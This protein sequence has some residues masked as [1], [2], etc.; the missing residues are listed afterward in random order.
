MRPDA[1]VVVVGAGVA[2]L[3]AAHELRRAGRDVRVLEAADHVGGRMTTLRRDGFLIDTGAEQLPTRGYPATWELLA[4]LGL[5]RGDAPRIRRHL[6]VWRDGRAR[7]GL[8]HPRGLLTG[9]GLPVAARRALVRALSDPHDLDHPE[10]GPHDTVAAYAAA[11]HPDLLRYLCQPVVSGFF[12]WDPERSAVA[13]LLAILTSCGT[14]HSWRTYRDGMDTFARALAADLDVEC[15]ARVDGVVAEPGGARVVRGADE[16]RARAVVLA[17]PAPVARRLH[18]NPPDHER[19]YLDACTYT[20]VLKAHLMLDT[21]PRSRSYVL[22]VPSVESAALSTIILDH[23]KHPG[24]APAGRGLVSL[25][26]APAAT[27]SLLDAPDH[28]VVTALTT[29]AERFLP[30]VGAVRDAVVSRFRHG[31]PEATPA[32][33]ALRAGFADRLGGVVDYAGDWV[34]LVPCSEAAVRSGRRAAARVLAAV[35]GRQPV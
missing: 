19:L 6:A 15:G 28:E 5:G 11:R 12:G 22:L 2:G 24:R 10:R 3:T 9:A 32:A 7:P 8:A 23:V 31:L 4:R 16:I 18:A 20:P 25:M 34:G 13:P 30:E 35:P 17:V 21:R 14:T 26:A 29:A 27:P 1:D 33:L